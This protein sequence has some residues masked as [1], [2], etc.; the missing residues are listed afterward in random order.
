MWR[1]LWADDRGFVVSTELVLVA[2]L[3]VVG[4][5]VGLATLRDQ[6]VQELGDVAVAVSDVNHS[7]SFSGITGHSASTAGSRFLDLQ[8]FCDIAGQRNTD[9]GPQCI[10]VQCTIS[11]PEQ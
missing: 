9:P 3:V 1:L 2:V 5:L 7:F 6:V 4:M 10:N 8:D 11:T